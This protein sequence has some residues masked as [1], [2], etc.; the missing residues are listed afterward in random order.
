MFI[1][2][3]AALPTAPPSPSAASA[4]NEPDYQQQ[5][6]RPNGGIDNRHDNARAEADPELRKQPTPDQGANN[7]DQEITDNSEPGALH[8]L[9]SK[10]TR[11]DS[12][13]QYHQKTFARQVHVSSSH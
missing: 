6:D 11:D 2:P 3:R 5:D 9:A 12:D 7:S 8:D 13:E 4:A 10:P 1:E